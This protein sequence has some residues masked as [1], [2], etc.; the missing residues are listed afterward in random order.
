MKRR[1]E[2]KKHPKTPMLMC[3]WNLSPSLFIFFGIA[4]KKTV[5]MHQGYIKKKALIK[6]TFI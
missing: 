1:K 2:E 6:R 5:F 4:K 3:A